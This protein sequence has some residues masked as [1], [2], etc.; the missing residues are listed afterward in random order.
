MN[1]QLNHLLSSSVA[2]IQNNQLD[3][4]EKLLKKALMIHPNHPDALR[5]MGVIA[6]LRKDWAHAL[7]LIDQ[8]LELNP[9]NGIAFSNKGNILKELGQFDDALLC[10]DK[11]IALAPNY[12]EA[13]NNKGNTLQDLSRFEE[14]LQCYDKAASLAP[15]YAEARSNKGNALRV[16][17]RNQ[18]ALVCYESALKISPNLKDAFL[19]AGKSLFELNQLADALICFDSVLVLDQGN[20]SAWLG[21][22]DILSLT[23][24]HSQAITCFERAL[25]YDPH[26]GGALSMVLNSRLQI[27]D[28]RGY[29]GHTE[30]LTTWLKNGI[31]GIS[32]YLAIALSDSPQFI[33]NLTVSYVSDLKK[34]HALPLIKEKKCNEKIH[35]AY[36]SADFHNHPTAFLSAGL[37]E[38][39]DKSKFELTAFV[40]GGNKPDSMRER[41]VAA[42][43][44]FIDVSN[45]SDKE[46][47]LLA[48]SMNVD[49]AIDLKGLTQESR[50]KI[51]AC[52]AAPV[53]VNY[54]GYPG[55]MSVPF[56]DYLVA[57][58]V[59]IP[60]AMQKYYDEKI[61]YLPNSYQ[62]ND[63]TR[64]FPKDL[65]TRV[66]LGLPERG[67]VFCCFNNSY[68]ISPEIFSSWLRIL[69]S[70]DGSVLWLFEGNLSVANN[71][72]ALA[73]ESGVNSDRLI[74]AKRMDSSSHLARYQLADLFLDT[75]PCNAHTTASD[76]LWAGVPVLTIEGSAFS[77]RVA[78]S[79]LNAIGLPELVSPNQMAYE[80][81][82]VK[83]ATDPNMLNEIKIRLE[84]NKSICPL[85]NTKLFTKHIE[86]AYMQ[87]FDNYQSDISPEN[88]YVEVDK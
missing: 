77:A 25:E 64:V 81:L 1:K 60:D 46:I 53:Q 9:N 5:F 37:F 6:A 85:F 88:I 21:K 32:P 40:F 4:A 52:R 73:Q 71:L 24:N 66:E 43:D 80:A 59:I 65:F 3:D 82:A 30:T 10:F 39:H 72:K 84:L 62:V 45:L 63:Q 27:C 51:F 35:L 31:K 67:F 16:L 36:F 18:E 17:G 74:F 29:E 70:T 56:M 19:G 68:K 57:D 12:A 69:R 50:P 58:R 75:F 86:D 79:L 44:H 48:R 14:S 26:N 76:S 7:K 78:A 42:F 55:T 15:N 49:I 54:L 41:L 20:I 33:R 34:I 47:A 11:A 87:M 13:H 83:L 22:G 38:H 61:V 23:N 2:A 8:V 28:W